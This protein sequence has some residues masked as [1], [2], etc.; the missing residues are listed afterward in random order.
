MN[1]SALGA[2]LT[3]MDIV[4][5][6]SGYISKMVSAGDSSTGSQPAK[7]KILLLDSETVGPS[8]RPP[9]PARLLLMLQRSPSS[10]PPPLS[11]LCSAMKSTSP[12]TPKAR[13]KLDSR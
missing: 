6:V 2:A 4:Q 10:Q 9:A 11:R 1:P 7:M 8:P 5:S 13:S 12:S 3:T